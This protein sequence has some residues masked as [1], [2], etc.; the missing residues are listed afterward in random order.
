M[1]IDIDN[2]SVTSITMTIRGKPRTFVS[3]DDLPDRSVL[4]SAQLTSLMAACKALDLTRD[5]RIELAQILLGRDVISYR[6]LTA[7]EAQRLSDA[8][9]G[10]TYIWTIRNNRRLGS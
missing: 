3:L 9:S 10:F 8:L 1:Q 7:H 2:I 6:Y 5:D 4:S